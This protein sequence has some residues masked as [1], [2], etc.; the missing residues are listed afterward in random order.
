MQVTIDLPTGRTVA[1]PVS[2]ATHGAGVAAYV[3]ALLGCTPD[4]VRLWTA[5]G[6]S[7]LRATD[8]PIPG[9]RFRARVA[10]MPGGAPRAGGSSG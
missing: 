10:A 9:A 7:V 6:D 3:A 1:L 8:Q 4:R 2:E 5:G